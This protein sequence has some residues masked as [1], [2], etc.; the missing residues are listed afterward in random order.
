MMPFEGDIRG[1][2][3]VTVMGSGFR[4]GA[5]VAIGGAA[6]TSVRVVSGVSLTA[7]APP[8]RAARVV[9][10]AVTNPDGRRVERPEGFRYVSIDESGP[11][12]WDD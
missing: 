9:G 5:S 11:S 12:P 10:V 4:D 1:G 2:T 6:A 8:G 3:Y 7:I